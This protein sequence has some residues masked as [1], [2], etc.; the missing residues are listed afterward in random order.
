MKKKQSDTL[1]KPGNQPIRIKTDLRAGA[2]DAGN[3]GI[4]MGDVVDAFTTVTGIKAVTNVAEQI[5][6][7]DCGCDQRREEWNQNKIRFF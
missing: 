6:G 7:E 3:S 1:K 5:T 4:G 2:D